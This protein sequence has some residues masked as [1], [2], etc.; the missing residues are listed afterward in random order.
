MESSSALVGL[1]GETGS[2]GG[3]CKPCGGGGGGGGGASP[4]NDAGRD[5]E[6]TASAMFPAAA[7]ELACDSRSDS[8]RSLSLMSPFMSTDKPVGGDGDGAPV[9]VAGGAGGGL[10]NV[11]DMT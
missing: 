7:N 8:T 9:V 4:E 1:A 2:C 10:S 11:T 6:T 5:R 3:G